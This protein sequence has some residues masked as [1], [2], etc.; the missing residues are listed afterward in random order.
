M[1]TSQNRPPISWRTI[2][3]A[4]PKRRHQG[5]I[6]G[7]AIVSVLV[8]AIAVA[9]ADRDGDTADAAAPGGAYASA[10]EEHSPSG[11]QRAAA[12]MVVALGSEAMYRPEDRHAIL[13]RIADPA[14][15]E[16]QQ[17]GY[18]QNYSPAFNQKVGLDADGNAPAG[19]EFVNRMAPAGVSIP[20]YTKQRATVAVWSHA[21]FKTVDED[22]PTADWYTVTVKLTW[23]DAG[24]RMLDS[25]QT[26]GPT[27]DAAA[28]RYGQAPPL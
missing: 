7:A 16:Q 25:S 1:T 21:L 9:G 15:V 27:P 23:T 2:K 26:D 13:R 19:G 14:T 5:L 28:G 17:A 6:A 8:A 4:R 18:D 11:A 12:A 20:A 24:W 10:E 22:R 3:V